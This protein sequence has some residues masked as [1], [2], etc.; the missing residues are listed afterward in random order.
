M[1]CDQPESGQRVGIDCG[2]HCGKNK[3]PIETASFL[4][5]LYPLHSGSRSGAVWHVCAPPDANILHGGARPLPRLPPL[6]PSTATGLGEGTGVRVG[7]KCQ[8][9]RCER[10]LLRPVLHSCSYT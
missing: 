9:W 7:A 4:L 6:P 2:A 5:P 8:A 3:T 1:G 10:V